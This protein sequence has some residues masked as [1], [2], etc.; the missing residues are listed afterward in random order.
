MLIIRLL[1]LL[2]VL[3]V[4]VAGG[5]Y[6]LTGD[7]RYKHFAWRVIRYVL[8]AIVFFGLLMLLNTLR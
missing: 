4:V 8:Y 5:L 6:L 2:S 7:M 1:L 3:V